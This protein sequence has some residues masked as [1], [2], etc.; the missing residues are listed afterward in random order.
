MAKKRFATLTAEKAYWREHLAP[1]L[2]EIDIEDLDLI[3]WSLLRVKWGG[4]LRFLLRKNADGS[5][6]LF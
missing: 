6:F 5:G 4:R 1:Q 3:L 2:P